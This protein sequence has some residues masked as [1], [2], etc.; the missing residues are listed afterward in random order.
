MTKRAETQCKREHA[1]ASMLEEA[2]KQPG[3][4]D[5]L[6]VYRDWQRADSGLNAYRAATKEPA[7][8]VT[9]D[10]ANPG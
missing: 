7:R 8:V 10:H 1:R 2:L 3:V 9:T 6:A 4:R 5:V